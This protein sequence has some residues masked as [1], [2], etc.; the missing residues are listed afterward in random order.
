MIR[1]TISVGVATLSAVPD[2]KRKTIETLLN[3]AD[4]ALYR[5]KNAGR[6]RV[7]VYDNT[8]S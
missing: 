2:G 1:F 6:N 7:C 3:Q 4:Q 8:A 5:A